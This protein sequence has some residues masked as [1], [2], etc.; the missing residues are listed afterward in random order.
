MNEN[1]SA[2]AII[3]QSRIERK[4]EMIGE[5][6]WAYDLKRRGALGENI[7]IRNAPWDC[8]GMIL[9]FP[10]SENTSNFIMNITGGCN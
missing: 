10:N 3:N 2:E 8:D 4:K 9:Q 1:S 7:Q 5:G 6:R